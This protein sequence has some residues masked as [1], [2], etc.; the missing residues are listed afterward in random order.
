M[1]DRAARQA[2][3]AARRR[4]A[5]HEAQNRV[6]TGTSSRLEAMNDIATA[7]EPLVSRREVAE[8]IAAAL[9][10]GRIPHVEVKL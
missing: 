1:T 10:D 4:M 2:A 5:G 7:L 3:E 6:M 8:H 9:I